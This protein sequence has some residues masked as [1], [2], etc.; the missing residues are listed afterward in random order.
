[1]KA[2]RAPRGSREA[3]E[4]LG[5]LGGQRVAAYRRAR[6]NL[7]SAH[8][9]LKALGPGTPQQRDVLSGIV[10]N[11]TEHLREASISLVQR[12]PTTVDQD[13]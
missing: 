2:R 9:A 3:N 10:A 4:L 8:D 1:M 13:E 6:R 12:L 11:I 7:Q 5:E